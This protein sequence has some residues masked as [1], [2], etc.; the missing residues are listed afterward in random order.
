[1]K[2]FWPAIIILSLWRFF[3]GTRHG[4]GVDESHYVLY[5][6]NLDWS[7]FDHPPLIGWVQ[8]VFLFV[9]GKHEWSARIP[10][11]LCGVLSS[12]LV[13]RFIKK[14]S[15][16]EEIAFWSTL[17]LNFSFLP[18]ALWIMF[19]PDTLLF[20][21]ALWLLEI[22]DNILSRENKWDWIQL[23]VCLGLAGL[24]KYTAI[25][26][27]IS[28]LGVVFTEKAW[29][30][31]KPLWFIFATIIGSILVFPVFYW[32]M[33]HHWISFAYQT[34]HVM[35]ST[36]LSPEKF[37]VFL[38]G[39]IMAYS[40]FLTLA[41]I[42]GIWISRKN[43]T[44]TMRI[45]LWIAVPT[46]LFFTYTATKDEVLPHWTLLSWG[47]II[48][49]GI[50][51]GISKGRHFKW[52]VIASG[53]VL[54]FVMAELSLQFLRFPAYQSPY[55]DLVGWSSL[56]GE[57]ETII[58]K[59]PQGNFAIV[60]PNWT[61]GGRARFYLGDLAPVFVIDDRF[62]Q[63]DLWEENQKKAPDLLV[64][65]WRGF[66]LSPNNTKKCKQIEPVISRIF[67]INDSPVNSV[68]ITWCRGYRWQQDL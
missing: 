40:P 43:L 64:L 67:S 35:G 58:E 22:L 37:A 62:D 27:V 12:F 54:V 59:E 56:H 18:S 57:I 28:I 5:G 7:Y 36:H 55:A 11:I 25:F 51:L 34:S 15:Q 21:L 3:I 41:G 42:W 24:S 63:Y 50:S 44:Q 38:L 19:L 29:K 61:L 26:F 65:S 23:G 2:K 8:S 17:A 46:F 33:K 39:Q 30:K 13:F 10:A 66:D 49:L 48:P 32:N 31:V 60:V 68:Q 14:I 9:F 1:M 20:I 4:L 53:V 6:L 52:P 16:S 47:I 45:A